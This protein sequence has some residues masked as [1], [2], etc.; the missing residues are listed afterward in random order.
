MTPPRLYP[1][2]AFDLDGTVYLGDD[3]LP[4]AARTIADLR[5]AG[6]RVVFVTNKP[7]YSARD[8]AEKLTALG[9]PA[10][11]E[12]VVT[13]GD[14]LVSYLSTHHPGRRLL[15]VAEQRLCDELADAGFTLTDDPAEADVVVVSFD[16]TFTYTK[17][18]GAYRAVRQ[19]GATIVA[20]NPDAYCPTPDGGLP[21]CA[22]ML[23][24]VEASTGVR[25]EAIVGKPSAYMASALLD[26]LGVPPEDVAV[27]G[28]RLSTD[29][30]MG[31]SIGA[32]GILVLTG[33]TSAAAAA[34]HVGVSADYVIETLDELTPAP[35]RGLLT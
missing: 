16:R 15:P 12:D 25:A 17:L 31:Q 5:A 11:R 26:R 18:L 4:G 9:I 24:A 34:A 13:A 27:V 28:D 21:D 1:A 32:T 20:T 22:A 14:A 10:S 19:Y 6:A 23:A 35:T 2:Y 30:A 8:Y 29:V 33:A 3:L 7:L